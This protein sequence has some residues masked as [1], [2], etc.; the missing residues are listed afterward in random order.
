[1]LIT[2]QEFSKAKGIVDRYNA[3]QAKYQGKALIMLEGDILNIVPEEDLIKWL[4]S[5]FSKKLKGKPKVYS[6]RMWSNL[7]NYDVYYRGESYVMPY[8]SD[9]LLKK[10]F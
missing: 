7:K 8:F 5:F 2:E 10:W 1:M 6:S 3:Q 4:D 9:E